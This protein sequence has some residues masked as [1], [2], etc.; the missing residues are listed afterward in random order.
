MLIL[1]S[2]IS[3]FWI[4][5]LNL[6]FD[7]I[8]SVRCLLTLWLSWGSPVVYSSVHVY[9][10]AYKPGRRN[11]GNLKRIQIFYLHL[12]NILKG[13]QSH[14]RS[15]LK[16]FYISL[17]S[18]ANTNSA[19]LYVSLLKTM[20]KTPLS[21]GNCYFY[22]QHLLLPVLQYV[23]GFPYHSLSPPHFLLCPFL[24]SPSES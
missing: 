20:K 11:W 22:K 17:P 16:S 4:L 3:V 9:S 2:G 23:S 10:S 5:I 18:S 6:N 13:T 15:F 1:F 24:E 7:T 12:L 8:I 19:F 14:Q 21:P